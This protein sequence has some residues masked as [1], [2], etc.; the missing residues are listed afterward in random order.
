MRTIHHKFFLLAAVAVAAIALPT[1]AAEGGVVSIPFSTA[2][3]SDPLD[4]DNP[5]FPLEPRTVKVFA[6]AGIEFLIPAKAR[7]AVFAGLW[8]LNE[9]SLSFQDLPTLGLF[10]VTCMLLPP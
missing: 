6:A 7:L 8:I 10:D 3:F 2:N 1:S 5:L 4:I 9:E